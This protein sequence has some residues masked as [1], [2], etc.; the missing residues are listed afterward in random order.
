VND[1]FICTCGHSKLV[2]DWCAFGLGL[3]CYSCIPVDGNDAHYHEFKPDNLLYLES[4][5]ES[6]KE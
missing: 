2:H 4:L 1:K 6:T 5:S 3:R